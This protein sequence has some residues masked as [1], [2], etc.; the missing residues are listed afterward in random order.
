[1]Y[2]GQIFF[3]I[4]ISLFSVFRGSRSESVVESRLSELHVFSLCF[5]FVF[6]SRP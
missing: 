5:V 4:I 1:M 2:V 6:S 3:V